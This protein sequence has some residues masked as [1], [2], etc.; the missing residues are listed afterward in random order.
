[1]RTTYNELL[2]TAKLLWRGLMDIENYSEEAYQLL[3]QLIY[4]LDYQ[5]GEEENEF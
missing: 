2:G 1:M 5:V 3:A 4:E